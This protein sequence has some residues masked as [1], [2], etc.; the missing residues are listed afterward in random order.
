MKIGMICRM[1]SSGLGNLS[2][3]FARHFKPTKIVLVENGIFHTFPERYKDFDVRQIKADQTI[4]AAAQEWLTDDTD[5]ILSCETFY[6]WEIVNVARRKQVKTVLV[7]MF[8]MTPEFLPTKPDLFLCPSTLDY[9]VMPEPKAYLPVPMATDRLVW[10]ERKTAKTFIH[11]A[12]HGGMNLRKGTPILLEAMNHVRSNIKL[13]IYS[14]IGFVSTDPRVEIRHV[15]FKNYWQI[16]REGDVL[17]YPQ[18]YNGICLPVMEAFA[19]GLGI[20]TTD[21][22]PFNQYLPKRLLFPHQGTHK[23][24]AHSGLMEVEAARIDAKDLARKIDEIADSD[25]SDVSRAGK[26]WAS[27]HS[28]DVLLPQY[29]QLFEKLCRP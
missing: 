4:D 23:I 16:W 18:D 8:E 14:W 5:I 12:S 1:D 19:S 22:Y 20:I 26:D 28:W 7:T 15:H 27:Q 13:I 6:N 9:K 24:R 17:V 21:I 2:W 10:K 3:E 25:I 11:T 29:I